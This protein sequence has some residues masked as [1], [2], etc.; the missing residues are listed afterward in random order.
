[1][2]KTSV[3]DL[4]QTQLR[5][6]NAPLLYHQP[7]NEIIV[8]LPVTLASGATV[9][10]KGYRVQHNNFRGPYKGGLRFDSVVHLDECKIDTREQCTQVFTKMNCK[11]ND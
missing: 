2:S 3:Y 1:M 9:L 6:A 8:H 4:F 10:F 7:Q 11:W 5:Q